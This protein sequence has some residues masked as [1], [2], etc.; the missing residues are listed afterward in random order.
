MSGRLGGPRALNYDV[1]E[2][3]TVD[4]SWGTKG[5]DKIEPLPSATS[6]KDGK[7]AAVVEVQAVVQEGAVGYRRVV[8]LLPPH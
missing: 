6:K 1:L 8:H 2:T 7:S 3:D 4:D 5:S